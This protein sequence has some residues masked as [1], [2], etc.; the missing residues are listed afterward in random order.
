MVAAS[1][2]CIRRMGGVAKALKLSYVN[3]EM[4]VECN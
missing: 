1:S 3:A 2:V 4:S